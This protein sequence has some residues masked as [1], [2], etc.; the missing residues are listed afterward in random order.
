M[1]ALHGHMRSETPPYPYLLAAAAVEPAKQSSRGKPGRGWRMSVF[2][3]RTV[4]TPG[5]ARAHRRSRGAARPAIHGG[6]G[7]Q[8]AAGLCQPAYP[9]PSQHNGAATPSLGE[10]LPPSN[11]RRARAQRL[12]TAASAARPPLRPLLADYW[13]RAAAASWRLREERSPANLPDELHQKGCCRC[14]RWSVEDSAASA[15][16]ESAARNHPRKGAKSREHT[17]WAVETARP[18]PRLLQCPTCL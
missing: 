5:S 6:K 7:E 9:Q 3:Q 2:S 16:T 14:S 11:V 10:A 15:N 4:A 12:G 13:Q 8:S 17:C 1:P 18:T